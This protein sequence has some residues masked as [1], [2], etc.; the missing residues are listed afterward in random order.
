[1]NAGWGDILTGML[2]IPVALAVAARIRFWP[3]L[4]VAWCLIGAG[5]L[6]LA[7][8]TA[9]LYGGPTVDGFSHEP[10]PDLSRAATRHPAARRD[11]ACPL[12]AADHG[13]RGADGQGHRARSGVVRMAR[14]ARGEIAGPGD[15]AGFGDQVV[16][17]P[18]PCICLFQAASKA[19]REK[20]GRA[21]ITVRLPCANA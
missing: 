15:A 13:R 10:H 12:A 8:L 9:V 16:R 21:P 7:P 3:L 20:P 6:V 18:L 5:D 19:A 1:M 11:A 14:R 4:V 2:A 17:R